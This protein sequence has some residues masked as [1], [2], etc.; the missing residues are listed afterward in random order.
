VFYIPNSS[1]EF[2]GSNAGL[3]VPGVAH[4]AITASTPTGIVTYAEN[5]LIMAE[6][7]YRLGDQAGA[8]STLNAFRASVGAPTAT[9]PGTPNGLL[10]QILLEKFARLF[11]N[12]EV[13][14]D[15]LRTCVPNVP[16]PAAPSPDFPYM[17]ARL[18]YGYTET[19]ANAAEPHIQNEPAGN[20]ANANF[21]K[22][23]TD[24]T[25]ATCIQ[26]VNRPGP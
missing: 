24:P 9:V 19:V 18:P 17:P 23:A 20:L 10:V 12:P 4:F 6:A 8:L 1:G 14:F 3:T 11:I 2:I 7:Q 5:E 13:Y 21:P 15:Y 25:G 16:F 22:N 26:Q